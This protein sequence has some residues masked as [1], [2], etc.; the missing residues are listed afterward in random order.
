MSNDHYRMTEELSRDECLHLLQEESFVGRVGFISDGRPMILPVNYLGE[1]N[2]V[3]ICTSEGTLLDA[4]DEGAV[5]AFEVDAFRTLY[6]AGW[7]VLVHGAI[8]RI[9]DPVEVGRLQA[10]PLRSWSQ[11]ASPRWIRIPVAEIT[12]RRIPE[13]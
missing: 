13:S 10:G 7:S 6:N 8:Q 5:V 12:G 11:P 1:A 2:A 3:V 9:V 4:L